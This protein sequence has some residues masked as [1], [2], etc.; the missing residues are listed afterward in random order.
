MK[1]MKLLLMAVLF[2]SCR[3]GDKSVIDNNYIQAED[4][5]TIIVNSFSP[6]SSL[7]I[8]SGVV[9]VQV[10]GAC[11]FSGVIDVELDGLSIGSVGCVGNTFSF[12]VSAADLSEGENNLTFSYDNDLVS[13]SIYVDTI[14]PVISL[15]SPAAISSSNE[16]NYFLSGTCSEGSGNLDFSIGALSFSTS[17]V[18]NSWSATVDVSSLSDS[19]SLS[20]T[21]DYKD[22]AQNSAV[23]ISSTIVK[24]TVGPTLSVTYAPD[25]NAANEMNYS[26]VGACSDDGQTI[27]LTIGSIGLSSTCVGGGWTS[28]SVDVSGEPDTPSLAVALS[29]SDAYGNSSITS[30]SIYKLSNVPTVTID[31]FSNIDQSN[32][33]TYSASGSCSQVGTPVSVSIGALSFTPNCSG[34]LWSLSNV[35]VSSLADNPSI[36]FTADHSSATQASVSISKDTSLPTVSILSASNIN[37]SNEAYY[38]VTGTCSENGRL[39]NV[40]LDSGALSFSPTCSSGSWSIGLQDVSSLL[41]G[42][43]SITADHDNASSV[44][45]NQAMV[46]V[47]KETSEPSVDNLQSPASYSDEIE[48]S[49]DLLVPGGQ[50]VEDYIICYRIEA[51]PTWLTFNDGVSTNE[52]TSVTSLQAST[53]YEFRVKVVFDSGQESSWSNTISVDTKPDNTIFSSPYKAMNVG[54]ATTAAVVA[55]EDSTN[56]TLNDAFL[57][58]LDAGETHVFA[59]SQFDVIDADGPIF[60]AGRRGSGSDTQKGNITFMP[61]AWAGKSFSFNAIRNNPQNLQVYAIEDAVVEVYN[62]NTLLDSASISAGAGANLSWSTYGSYQIQ[63][64]GF[65]LAYHYSGSGST[66]VDPK[67]ILPAHTEI[68][69]IPSSSMR[70]TTSFDST[71]YNFWHSNSVKGSN[72]MNKI[73]SITYNPQGTSSYFNGSTL[74]IRSDRLISGASFADGNGNCATPFMPTNLLKRNYAINVSSDYVAFSSKQSG[75]IDI[76]SPGQTVGVDTP[77]QSLSLTNSGGDPN[78]PYKARLGVTPAGYR[79]I[80]TAPMAVWYQPQ[81]DTGAANRDETILYGSD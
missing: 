31:S 9:D 61:T 29:G 42:T 62:G 52:Y 41:D 1:A 78:A 71:N 21:A 80:S 15:N 46:S 12:V 77:V 33:L 38:Q 24:D 54:G 55:L 59:T 72:T 20:F 26:I 23:Q 30:T 56:V 27:N 69:G 10:D 63:S 18:S 51:T 3:N 13:T 17:C 44:A 45:A 40:S 7:N 5:Q 53:T 19:A 75:T 37:A 57:V 68:L 79:F 22:D 50:V 6:S 4:A 60:T 70:L 2:T 49:W 34:G 76:Y 36:L 64:T 8:L 32:E 73:D 16:T 28:G 66:I 74:L 11:F 47:V 58:T 65:I 48:L 39:V 43:I 81:T 67:P 25:I 35:N 14:A